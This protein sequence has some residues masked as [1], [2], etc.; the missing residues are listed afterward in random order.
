MAFCEAVLI[1][2]MKNFSYKSRNCISPTRIMQ[3]LI[4]PNYCP[5][6]LCMVFVDCIMIIDHKM[7]FISQKA[8]IELIIGVIFKKK[9][10]WTKSCSTTQRISFVGKISSF[11][12]ISSRFTRAPFSRIPPLPINFELPSHHQPT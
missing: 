1:L 3:C 8:K 12:P 7:C 6:H 11:H 4:C 9:Y 5:K 2:S 10:D